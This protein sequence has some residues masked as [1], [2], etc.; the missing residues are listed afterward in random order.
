MGIIWI[1]ICRFTGTRIWRVSV[2]LFVLMFIFINYVLIISVP[3]TNYG[4]FFR[5]VSK[6]K[7]VKILEGGEPME[8]EK[9]ETIIVNEKRTDKFVPFEFIL[10]ANKSALPKN[11]DIYYLMLGML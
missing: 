5:D 9:F 2:F 11:E 3:L 6:Q 10:N 7:K 1:C 4:Q 8:K